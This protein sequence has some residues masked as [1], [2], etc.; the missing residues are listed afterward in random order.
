[1][2]IFI[3][4][5]LDSSPSSGS[6]CPSGEQDWTLPWIFNVKHQGNESK[7]DPGFLHVHLTGIR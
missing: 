7:R 6:S 3:H 4:D 2:T 5:H 1:M